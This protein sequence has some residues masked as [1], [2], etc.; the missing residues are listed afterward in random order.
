MVKKYILLSLC[1][2]A[3]LFFL[4]IGLAEAGTATV[5]GKV[6]ESNGTTPVAGAQ[7]MI[8]VKGVEIDSASCNVDFPWKTKIVK[9]DTK[10]NYQANILFPNI[11]QIAFEAEVIIANSVPFKKGRAELRF[12]GKPPVNNASY[13]VDV[14]LTACNKCVV[15]QGDVSDQ[16]TGV[17]VNLGTLYIMAPGSGQYIPL[18]SDGHYKACIDLGSSSTGNVTLLALARSQVDYNDKEIKT[19]VT[20]GKVYTYDFALQRVKNTGYIRGTVIDANTGKPIPYALVRRS[21]IGTTAA[22]TYCVTD[23]LGRYSIPAYITGGSIVTTGAHTDFDALSPY[24]RQVKRVS[25]RTGDVV[26]VDFEMIR[27]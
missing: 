23:S 9:T 18:H 10:G 4:I 24:Y 7:V 20:K 12:Y 1:V 2:G 5:R 27:K 8:R 19:S 26:R 21:D 25:A 15:V 16:E 22:L 11:V 14:R 3:I 13:R 6:T 17:A